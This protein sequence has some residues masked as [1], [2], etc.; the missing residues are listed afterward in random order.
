M[1]ELSKKQKIVVLIFLVIIATTIIYYVYGKD[2]GKYDE[3]LIPYEENYTQENIAENDTDA[4]SEESADIIIYITGAVNKEGVYGLPEGSRIADAIE[5]AQGLKEEASTDIINLAYKLEDGMKIKI[6]TKEEVKNI[7]KEETQISEEE[8]ITKESGIYSEKAQKE[9]NG[10][11]NINIAT[12]E[13]LET[14]EGIGTSTANKIIQYRK[15]NGNFKSIEDI[16]NVSGIGDIKFNN[17]KDSIC[18][19]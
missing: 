2:T 19:K 3:E 7:N 14:L 1:K 11:I 6:P 4:Q 5:K 9:E 8:Y 15:K 16:K 12:Q 17:I 13:E 10:K 18:V